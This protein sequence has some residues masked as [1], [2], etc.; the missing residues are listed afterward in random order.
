[1]SGHFIFDSGPLLAAISLGFCESTS[2]KINKKLLLVRSCDEFSKYPDY[3]FY[4]SELLKKVQTIHTTTHVI[5]ELYGLANSRLK[6]KGKQY[7]EFWEFTFEYLK[8]NNLNEVLINLMELY[9]GKETNFLLEV[10]YVDS[11]LIELGRK[12][13]EPLLSLDRELKGKAEPKLVNCFVLPDDIE[14][15]LQE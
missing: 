14:Y 3:D 8:S 13:R 15:L 12:V 10:G 6:L 7:F 9:S 4:L 1:M 2:L 5:G 11:G